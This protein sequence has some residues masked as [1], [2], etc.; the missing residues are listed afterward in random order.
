MGAWGKFGSSVCHKELVGTPSNFGKA[1]Q[2]HHH[3]RDVCRT[4]FSLSTMRAKHHLW[5]F[6]SLNIL[7]TYRG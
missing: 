5:L 2:F 3:P 4:R 1:S 7:K 6:Q